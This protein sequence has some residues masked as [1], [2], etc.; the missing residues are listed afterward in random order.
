MTRLTK[1]L[2]L[3]GTVGLSLLAMGARGAHASIFPTLKSI[4]SLGDGTFRWTYDVS[5]DQFE[6]VVGADLA[7]GDYFT[8]YDFGGLVPASN[9]Q[10]NGWSFIS[11]N[12]GKTSSRVNPVDDPSLPNLTW[13]YTPAGNLPTEIAGP[14]DI[15]DFSAVSK[16]GDPMTSDFSQQSTEQFNQIGVT[17][18]SKTDTI[19]W[20]GAPAV[21][22]PGSLALLG[23]G[24]APLLGELRRRVRRS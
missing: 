16:S 10:P 15:G 21:P 19:G 14:F 9:L 2:L 23:L 1:N 24:V 3:A 5:V 20:V 13:I 22:E 18:G 4:T 11:G 17:P 6:K 8:I 7:H 12:L